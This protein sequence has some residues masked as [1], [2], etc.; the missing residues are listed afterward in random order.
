MHERRL[1]PYRLLS[2]IGEGG[3]GTVYKALHMTLQKVVALKVLADNQSSSRRAIARFRR[4]MTATA[5]FDHPNVIRATDAG[6]FE[7]VYFL[8]MEHID[9]VSLSRL[10]DRCGPLSVANACEIVRQ[11]AL[12]LDHI[13]RCGA[14]HRDIK[15]ANVMLTRHGQV[16][17]IDMGL[18]LVSDDAEAHCNL[19]TSEEL[20]GSFDY[21]APE[22]ARDSRAVNLAADL[23]G[24][25]ATL[26]QLLAGKPPFAGAEFSSPMQKL[27]AAAG[28]PAPPV[29]DG[30][31]DVPAE[32][33]A[34]VARLLA[35]NPADRFAS[36]AELAAAIAPFSAASDLVQL[37][38]LAD[39]ER[40]PEKVTRQPASSTSNDLSSITIDYIPID[41][42]GEIENSD[43]LRDAVR[44]SVNPV[45]DA[46]VT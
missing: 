44:F 34:I 42:I 40:R 24:L 30:R 25:G 35:K 14:I 29:N 13:H 28:R 26:Y 19:A 27:L 32:L 1:G 20:V 11:A 2:K 21:M 15:P 41:D 10:I 31:R 6:H 43:T 39:S 46:N 23:Y 36:A 38:A 45:G 4:E 22:Q 9:G 17:I 16:K 5:R 18:A 8:I 7:G 33:A 12:G 37:A 3:M